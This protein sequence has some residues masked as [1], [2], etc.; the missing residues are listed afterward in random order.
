MTFSVF[1]H[2][3][4]HVICDFAFCSSESWHQLIS[5]SNLQSAGWMHWRILTLFPPELFLRPWPSVTTRWRSW[6]MRPDHTYQP[7]R[8]TG[9]I[10]P[11][12]S[13]R[14]RKITENI[15]ECTMPLMT[16]EA[17]QSRAQGKNIRIQVLPVDFNAVLTC[18]KNLLKHIKNI[19]SGVQRQ[20]MQGSKWI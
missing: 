19:N 3:A 17:W 5:L 20:M 9:S 6:R 18:F 8:D 11:G 14:T 1:E 12:M 13:V 16:K 4:L 10:T 2:Q 15:W 7:S